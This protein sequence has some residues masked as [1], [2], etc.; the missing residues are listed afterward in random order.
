MNHTRLGLKYDQGKPRFDYIPPYA[1]TQLAGVLTFGAKKYKAHSWRTVPN[2][3]ERY[4]AA[5]LRHVVAHMGGE[6]K[7]PETGLPH[8]AHAM[9]NA[10]FLI[11]LCKED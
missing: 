9:C 10:A 8:M 5:L 1:L 7:D 11:E 6:S 3:K 2:G 4:L